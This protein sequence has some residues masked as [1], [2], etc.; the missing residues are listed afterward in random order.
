MTVEIA[1]TAL[2]ASLTC[3]QC[4]RRPR[5][6]T[7]VFRVGEADYCSACV[8]RA[9]EWLRESDQHGLIWTD[10]MTNRLMATLAEGFG[11]GAM[12]QSLGVPVEAV[13]AK[14]AAF[15]ITLT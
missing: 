1:S 11:E 8:E 12:A 4:N 13:R 9:L 6:K 3:A 7:V 10:A 14:L 15:G 5:V 2:A